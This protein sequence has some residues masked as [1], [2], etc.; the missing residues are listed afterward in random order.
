MTPSSLLYRKL[1]EHGI[2]FFV[3]VPC[4]LLS[5]L[6]DLLENDGDVV[7]T[8]VTREEEGVGVMAGAFL[9]GKR[10]ALVMQNSG[11][12][13]CVNAIVSLANYYRLPLVFVL[14]HRGTAGEK[15]DAQ[16]PMGQATKDLLNAVDVQSCA[17][18]SVGDLSLMDLALADAAAN[19][20]S[21]A[22]LLPFSFWQGK[23]SV[24]EAI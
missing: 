15:I 18:Q 20:R 11:L 24:D 19:R 16:R 6:I 2:D 3:S 8:P 5:E 14:S 21:V 17:I 9:A 10:P 13:N 4:K 23:R 12:G 22:F 7:Y 1:K